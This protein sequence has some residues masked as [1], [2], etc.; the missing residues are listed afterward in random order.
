MNTTIPTWNRD[1]T[2][3][4]ACNVRD[5]GG[6]PTASG[7]E[8]AWRKVLR[9][10]SLHK[11]T[12][13]DR[14]ELIDL[15]VSQMID[16]RYEEEVA[17]A[18]NVFAAGTDVAYTNISLISGNMGI[19]TEQL[20]QNLAEM[21]MGMLDDSQQAIRSVMQIIARSKD[22]IVLYHCT[23]GKDRTGVISALLLSLAGVS[24]EVI[25]QDYALTTERLQAIM[26]A[27]RAHRPAQ[28]TE[29]QYDMFLGSEPEGMLQMLEYM[30]STYHGADGYLR[31]IGISPD[32]IAALKRRMM[33]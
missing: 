6:Y 4:G 25:A 2:L 26:P 28:L 9:A 21:Y 29:E 15:G 19:S 3:E 5:L 11:L 33:E 1:I 32:E 12:A 7:Q 24:H 16:L 22:G 18:P 17:Q 10:D 30:E 23:A 13:A 31:Y 20:P 14:Q 8:T 27:L